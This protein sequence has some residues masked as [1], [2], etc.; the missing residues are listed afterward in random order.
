[1]V[2]NICNVVSRCASSQK[3]YLCKV[4]TREMNDLNLFF[5]KNVDEYF[6]SFGLSSVHALR[7]HVKRNMCKKH[8]EMKCL[9]IDVPKEQPGSISKENTTRKAYIN[10]KRSA[11]VISIKSTLQLIWINLSCLRGI[12]FE[13]LDS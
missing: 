10:D 13:T 7:L 11:K 8:L 12:D 1:M 4:T 9:K 2:R 6:L 3:R 5:R